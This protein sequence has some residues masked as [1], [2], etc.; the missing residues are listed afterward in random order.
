[1]KSLLVKLGVI[2]LIGLAIFAYAGMSQAECAWVLWRITEQIP[3]QWSAEKALLSWE[4]VEAV[5][6]YEHCVK[7]G[8]TFANVLKKQWVEHSVERG[9]EKVDITG[10]LVVITFKNKDITMIQFKC[11]PDTI[12]PRK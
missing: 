6:Q 10:S 8:D 11:F 7:L 12:D 4:L 3:G 5:P 9:V 2:L 1:M